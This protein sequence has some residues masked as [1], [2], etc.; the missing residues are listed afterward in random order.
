MA[1]QALAAVSSVI[2]S[3]PL[4]VLLGTAGLSWLLQGRCDMKGRTH[5]LLHIPARR[6]LNAAPATWSGSHVGQL[7][8][9]LSPCQ[10]RFLSGLL[11]APFQC[12]L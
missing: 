3:Q 4:P 5:T 7:G 11:L 1:F 8:D 2:C 6:P 12:S 9:E 10:H